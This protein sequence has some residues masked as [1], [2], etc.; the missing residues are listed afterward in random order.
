MIP[1]DRS[2]KKQWSKGHTSSAAMG[3]ERYS[4]LVRV[5]EV[6]EV[7][8]RGSKYESRFIFKMSR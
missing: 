7:V 5:L 8:G 3:R 6:S 4:S 2:P 1:P